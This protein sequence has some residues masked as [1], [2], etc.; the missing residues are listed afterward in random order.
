MNKTKRNIYILIIAAIISILSIIIRIQIGK[1]GDWGGFFLLL[2]FSFPTSICL[3]FF[4]PRTDRFTD[5]LGNFILSILVMAP[6]LY[7]QFSIEDYFINGHLKKYGIIKKA[8]I[9]K[10][11]DSKTAST[12]YFDFKINGKLYTESVY[13]HNKEYRIG[14]TIKILVSTNNPNHYEIID[15]IKQTP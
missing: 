9:S 2:T 15:Y 8:I 6:I 1:N 5:K 4:T 12:Y 3:I 14:D 7:I 10:Y 11:S 13:I